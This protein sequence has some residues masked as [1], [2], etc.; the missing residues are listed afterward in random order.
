MPCGCLLTTRRL[1]QKVVVKREKN[2]RIVLKEFEN[3]V[4]IHRKNK[5]E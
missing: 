1:S 4:G 5:V 3:Y 2:L